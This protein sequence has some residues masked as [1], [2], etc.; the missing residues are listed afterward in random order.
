LKSQ[1]KFGRPNRRDFVRCLD[2]RIIVRR[3]RG[4]GPS[5]PTTK[6]GGLSYPEVKLVNYS[7]TIHRTIEID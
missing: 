7:K 2:L 4:R 3:G 5:G 6:T 1:D